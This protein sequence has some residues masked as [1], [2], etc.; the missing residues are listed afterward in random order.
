MGGKLSDRGHFLFCRFDE[1]AT[2]V[3]PAS[4]PVVSETEPELVRRQKHRDHAA[5]AT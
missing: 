5:Q 1:T 3:R 2:A 4:P